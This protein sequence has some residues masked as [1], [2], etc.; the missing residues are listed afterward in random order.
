M[1][2]RVCSA[3]DVKWARRASL[4]VDALRMSLEVSFC[5]NKVYFED[6]KQKISF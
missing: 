1:A 5:G 4:V 2:H 3:I 6:I